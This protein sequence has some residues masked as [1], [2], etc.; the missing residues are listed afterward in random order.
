MW[1]AQAILVWNP[2]LAAHQ[3]GA[4]CCVPSDFEFRFPPLGGQSSQLSTHPFHG[5]HEPEAQRLQCGRTWGSEGAR[6][7]AGIG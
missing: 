3:R 6:N 7:S 1:T 5:K 4:A 2:A